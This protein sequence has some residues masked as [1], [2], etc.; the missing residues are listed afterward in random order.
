MP[1]RMPVPSSLSVCG[2]GKRKKMPSS[3]FRRLDTLAN[4]CVPFGVDDLRAMAP[5][6]VVTLEG[7][8]TLTCSG[9]A[10]LWAAANPLA[11]VTLPDSLPALDGSAGGSVTVAASFGINWDYQLRLRKVDANTVRLGFYRKD[12]SNTSVS[13]SL[14]EGVTAGIGSEDLFSA[15]MGAVIKDAAVDPASLA[16]LGV[17]AAQIS[18]IQAAVSASAQRKL[19]VA[20]TATLTACSSRDAAFLYEFDLTALDQS[21]TAVLTAALQADLSSLGGAALPP[22]V[23]E[24]RSIIRNL[25]QSGVTWK[26]NLLGIYNYIS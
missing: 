6:A 16:A 5:G 19:E 13:V 20:M 8:G 23:R 14:S 12:G 26:L 2:N 18:G 21:G 1:P 22:G 9:S 4:F 7:T 15:L 24:I 11:T 25:H 17:P 10:S 3:D